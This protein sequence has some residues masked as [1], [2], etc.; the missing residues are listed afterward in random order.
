MKILSL[1][2]ILAIILFLG[3]V[4]AITSASSI[5]SNSK[6]VNGVQYDVN[7]HLRNDVQLCDLYLVEIVNEEGQLVASPQPFTLETMKYT[8]EEKGPVIGTRTA[9]IIM[10]SK[11]QHLTC[12]SQLN[13]FK[14][15]HTGMFKI[16]EAVYF[17][18]YPSVMM[19]QPPSSTMRNGVL[20]Q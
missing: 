2:S 13:P 15:S 3:S 18:L 14:A 8:F 12:P 4:S 9:M 20:L 11:I 19:S 16:G 17:N 5:G 10:D 7:I 1:I 6:P